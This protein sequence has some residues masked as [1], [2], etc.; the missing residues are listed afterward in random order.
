MAECA[1]EYVGK[2]L[3]A[4]DLALNYH[5]WIFELMKPFLGRRVVEVGAGTGGFSELLLK[6]ETD[7]LSLVEPSEM[8]DA[9]RERFSGVANQGSVRLLK[10][11]FSRLAGEIMSRRPDS[12]VYNNVL[13]H[14][15]DDIRE[16]ELVR[17]V[18]EP[19]GKVLIFV[20]AGRF[21]FS[22]FDR[23]I[24]HFRRYSRRELVKKVEQA[25]LRVLE[26]RK[27]DSL[28]VLPW[29]VKYRLLRFTSMEPRMV[30]LYDVAA[31]PVLRRLESVIRPPFGKNLFLAA[32]KAH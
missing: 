18:L 26:V 32:E 7:E 5:E 25:G 29:F 24:G 27:V 13:E 6:H 19:G 30:R 17:D 12:I 23:R 22:E 28:G 4:M 21:L 8:F 20:P 14:I 31:V 15:E 9:L 10:G 16:L 11:V 1:V 2:D 3:E